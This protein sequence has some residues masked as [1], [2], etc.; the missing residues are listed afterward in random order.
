[1]LFEE[2]NDWWVSTRTELEAEGEEITQEIFRERFLRKFFP[3]DVRGKKEIEYLEL[4]QGNMSVTKYA[5]K[6]V[7]LSKYYTHYKYADREF[8]KCIKFESG[9]RPEIKQAIGYQRI[10]RFSDLVDCCS[11]FVLKLWSFLPCNYSIGNK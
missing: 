3:E 10:R 8:S 9:L 1:M 2:A 6:F 5:A 11:F 4:K 7:E